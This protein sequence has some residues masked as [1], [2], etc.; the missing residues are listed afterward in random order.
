MLGSKVLAAAL[1]VLAITAGPVLVA[2]QRDVITGAI[3]MVQG[4]LQ[5]LDT[6]IKQLS[7]TDPNT[8]VGVLNAAQGAQTTLEKAAT[9]ISGA[10]D[11]SL[12]G[13]LGLQQTAGDLVTQVQTTLGDLEQKKPVFDQLGVSSVVADSLQQQKEGSGQLSEM[14]LSKIPAIARPIAQKS[15]G[16]LDTAIDSAIATFRSPAAAK[17]VPP[18]VPAAPAAP[19]APIVAPAVSKRA[20]SPA[21]PAGAAAAV[22]A[23]AV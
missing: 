4:S 10:D 8:A 23:A 22:G 5:K 18:A 6:A 13:A 3:G 12:I 20:A 11:L 1:Q 9:Q 19:A 2:R 15:T 16:Q 14:L 21:A 17:A 7:A